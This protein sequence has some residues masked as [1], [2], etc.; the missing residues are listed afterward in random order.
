[1]EVH[2]PCHLHD[3]VFLGRCRD[4]L[5]RMRLNSDIDLDNCFSD[6]HFEIEPLAHDSLFDTSPPEHNPSAACRDD[7]EGAPKNDEEYEEHDDD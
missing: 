4:L 2:H 1:M 3:L 7:N 6:R 5:E